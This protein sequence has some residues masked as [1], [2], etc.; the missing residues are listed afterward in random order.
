MAIFPLLPSTAV[1]PRRKTFPN[2]KANGMF[3]ISSDIHTL[4][5]FHRR[6]GS[7]LRRLR[8]TK[9][10]MVLTLKGKAAAVLQDADA[11]QRLLDIAARA[12]EAEGIRQGLIDADEGRIRPVEEFFAEFESRHDIPS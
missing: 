4:T 9:R 2:P 1:I 6:S 8:R 11:Y 10:P 12:D 5:A 7:F 3:F